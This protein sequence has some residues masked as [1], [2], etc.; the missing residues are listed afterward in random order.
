M[1]NFIVLNSFS[2]IFDDD[3]L[4]LDYFDE[5]VKIRLLL[6]YEFILG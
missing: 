2:D 3:F 1:G 5:V 6:N 4:N